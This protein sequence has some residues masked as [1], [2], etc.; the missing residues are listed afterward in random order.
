MK[1]SYRNQKE[2]AKELKKLKLQRKIAFEEIKL[3]KYEF[4]ENISINNW[5]TTVVK[6]ITRLGMYNLAK[7]LVR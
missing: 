3:I 4:K 7:K 2:I 5:M 1:K 6:T